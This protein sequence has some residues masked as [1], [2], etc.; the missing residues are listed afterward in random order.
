M[1][2]QTI[3]ASKCDNDYTVLK[4]VGSASVHPTTIRQCPI[5]PRFSKNDPYSPP[6][7]FTPRQFNPVWV[8]IVDEYDC[9][10]LKVFYV[11]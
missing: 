9:E 4:Y 6:V 5:R 10:S 2:K 7:L 1:S 11:L 8:Y 3:I